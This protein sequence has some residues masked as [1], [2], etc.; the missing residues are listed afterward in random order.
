MYRMIAVFLIVSSCTTLSP[1]E[2]LNMNWYE[3]GVKDGAKGH[4]AVWIEKHKQACKSSSVIPDRAQWLKGRQKGLKSYCTA[5]NAYWIGRKGQG[6]SP[7]CSPAAEMQMRPALAH[8]VKYHR[9]SN[10]IEYLRRDIQDARSDY[11][12]DV[13]NNPDGEASHYLEYLF[14]LNRSRSEIRH[15]Q[16]RLDQFDTWPP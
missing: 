10:E 7:V 16:R 15:L 4:Q 1:E 9:I 3:Q 13:Q 14:V 12:W 2:C 5:R 6:L 11:L 8:G